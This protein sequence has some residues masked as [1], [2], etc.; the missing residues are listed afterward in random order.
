MASGSLVLIS[1]PDAPAVPD[2]Q[3]E[4]VAK[5]LYMDSPERAEYIL[6]RFEDYTYT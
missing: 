6:R 4:G 1:R 3:L 5:R 2:E